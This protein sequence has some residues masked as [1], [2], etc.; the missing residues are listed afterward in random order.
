[1]I[2][3]AAAGIGGVLGG[4]VDVVATPS[5]GWVAAVVGPVVLPAPPRVGALAVV[6]V[7]VVVVVV[8]AAMVVGAPQQATLIAASPAST[9]SPAPPVSTV[10]LVRLDFT[11][12]PWCERFCGPRR[13]AALPPR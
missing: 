8:G 1:V 2:G 5:L 11:P 10:N 7:V 13:C 9:P 6:V 3:G 12:T 4:V